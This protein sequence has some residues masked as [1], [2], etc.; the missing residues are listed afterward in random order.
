[1]R[2]VNSVF[3]GAQ[4]VNLVLYDDTYFAQVECFFATDEERDMLKEAKLGDKILIKRV[5]HVAERATMILVGPDH[6]AKVL[7]EPDALD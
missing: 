5:C 1:M 3:G 2:M 6:I 4:Q 7:E